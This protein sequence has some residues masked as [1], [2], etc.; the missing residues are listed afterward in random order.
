[1]DDDIPFE[2]NMG[3]SSSYEVLVSDRV[4]MDSNMPGH[5]LTL[6]DRPIFKP[7]EEKF[8]PGQENLRTHRNT[9]FS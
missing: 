5:I 7:Q 6:A 8:W 9:H 2:A 3:V 4:R 1:M